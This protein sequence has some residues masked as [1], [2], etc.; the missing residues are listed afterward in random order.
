MREVSATIGKGVYACQEIKRGDA[1]CEYA[2]SLLTSREAT[3]GVAAGTIDE[4][5]TMFF[6]YPPPTGKQFA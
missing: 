6:K 3:E 5:Y 1:V 2:G 4:S